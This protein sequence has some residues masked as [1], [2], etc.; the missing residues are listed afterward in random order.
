[1]TIPFSPYDFFGYLAN[2]FLILCAVEYAFC[3]T[4]LAERDW[5]IGTAAFYIV[6]AYI[7]GHII[8]NV[9]SY[10]L[11]HKVVRE[12]LNSPE[13]TLFEPQQKTWRA[14]FF[15]IFY[16]PF[17]AET[18]KRVLDVAQNNGFD[19]PG[20]GLFL[21]AHAVVKQDKVTLERLTAFLNQYGFCRNV[22]MGLI[23][24][25]IILLIGAL[26]HVGQ[27]T[28]V[29]SYK[30]AWAGA[31]L[32]GTVGMFYRYLKFFRHYT[33]EVFGSYAELKQDKKKDE[34]KIP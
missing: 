6:L 27:W 29:D 31:A 22:S 9:S 19:K 26:I 32:V 7:I 15:P 23:I 5:K 4:S 1:M 10:L 11:E 2:G 28:E 17:P 16:R 25:A 13:E 3:G 20:R 12:W 8:A 33:M 14:F 21:H 30:L 18:Q 34:S 24:S